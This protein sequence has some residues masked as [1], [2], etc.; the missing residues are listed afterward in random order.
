MKIPSGQLGLAGAI[1][2]LGAWLANADDTSR[3]EHEAERLLL[4]LQSS[5][6]ES[7][8]SQLVSDIAGG[9]AQVS[10][11]GVDAV[12]EAQLNKERTVKE[13]SKELDAAWAFGEATY[14][15]ELTS[16][17][18]LIP[19]GNARVAEIREMLREASQHNIA[20]KQQQDNI[21][22]NC[23]GERILTLKGVARVATEALRHLEKAV[24]ANAFDSGAR[25]Y[26]EIVYAHK[27]AQ[28]GLRDVK[29][30]VGIEL[31]DDVEKGTDVA[32]DVEGHQGSMDYYEADARGSGD[33]GSR[34]VDTQNGN[35]GG[36]EGADELS[37]PQPASRSL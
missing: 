4:E 13:R 36:G 18:S 35:V 37:R 31:E 16:E 7:I 27:R 6:L 21:K 2:A 9:S 20:S 8:G 12:R 10:S 22:A 15:H 17:E 5:S 1:C 19:E 3:I 29:H 14:H 28:D 23:I 26:S 33:F 34:F 30:C 11:R 24:D 32:V 25:R